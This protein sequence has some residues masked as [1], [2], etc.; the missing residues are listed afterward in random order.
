MLFPAKS[1]IIAG[2]L[3]LIISFLLSKI[4]LAPFKVY[5]SEVS[6]SVSPLVLNI[7]VSLLNSA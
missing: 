1:V 3:E 4:K 5:P 6:N 2:S 7:F